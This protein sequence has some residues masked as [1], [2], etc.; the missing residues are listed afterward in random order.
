VRLRRGA[1]SGQSDDSR[2]RFGGVPGRGVK[3]RSANTEAVTRLQHIR[4][5]K[6]FRNTAPLVSQLMISPSAITMSRIQMKGIAFELTSSR[7]IFLGAL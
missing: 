2:R 3:H 1:G 5:V 4:A 7:S 6:Y